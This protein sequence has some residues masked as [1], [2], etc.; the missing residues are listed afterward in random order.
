MNLL[1]TTKMSSKGQ[2][3]IP[4]TIRN[5]L[6]LV[7]GTQFIVLGETDTVILKS[8]Q[9]PSLKEF[10]KLR[11]KARQQARKAGLEKT[12]VHKALKK[13]RKTK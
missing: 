11:T 13:A 12:N 7:P 9:A 5:Q 1:A 3:V 6:N 8:V 2:V 10:S 4:E